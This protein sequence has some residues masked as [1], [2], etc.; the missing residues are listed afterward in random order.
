MAQA[1]ASPEESIYRYH[2]S[3]GLLRLQF[4]PEPGTWQ[5]V[6]VSQGKPGAGVMACPTQALLSL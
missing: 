6:T 3:I 5:T 2:L 4:L 1:A